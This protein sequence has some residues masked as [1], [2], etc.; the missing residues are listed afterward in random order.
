MEHY[1]ELLKGGTIYIKNHDDGQLFCQGYRDDANEILI[2]QETSFPTASGGKF[3]VAIGIMKLIEENKLSL[4]TKIGD[5]LS[6]DLHQIDKNVTIKELLTHTSGIPNYFDESI[7]QDYSQLWTDFPN[8][9]IRTS[10][11]LLPLFI[12]KPMEFTHGDHFSYNDSGFVLLGIIIEEITKRS[13]DEYLNEIIFKPL[14]MNHT[15]YYELDRLPK[16]CA[17]AYI[18]YSKTNSYYTN[19][20]SV[21]AKGSGA[22]GAF[23]NALDIEKLWS[24]FLNYKLLKKETVELML[25][26]YAESEDGGYGLGVWLDDN[27]N[28]FI[29]GVDPGVTFISWHHRSNNQ[30]IT[31]N[32]N[33]YDN[34]FKIF[35]LIKKDIS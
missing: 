29:V 17:N 5:V 25:T 8:Y 21:D 12:H 16:N 2:N 23:T 30:S 22:G 26:K 10:K 32:S 4:D 13:F 33:Y 34:V 11:D 19:I 27:L 9:K 18:F 6:F 28:P 14:R 3:F 7:H 35:D 24:G 15:G 20:Y 31:I 1:V